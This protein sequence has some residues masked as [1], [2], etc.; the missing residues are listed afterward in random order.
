MTRKSAKLLFASVAMLLG[1]LPMQAQRV[2]KGLVVDA[3]GTAL[4]GVSVVVKGKEAAG[5]TTTIDGR[6]AITANPK[7]DRK[8]G[9]FPANTAS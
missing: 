9:R 6:Y 4:P 7:S 3:E 5:T 8:H 2:V 1:A